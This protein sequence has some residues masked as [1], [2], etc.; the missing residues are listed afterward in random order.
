MN[1]NFRRDLG[2]TSPKPAGFD[3]L[4]HVCWCA[5]ALLFVF[6][7]PLQGVTP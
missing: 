3:V 1:L 7:F 2:D 6:I 5:A 4:F